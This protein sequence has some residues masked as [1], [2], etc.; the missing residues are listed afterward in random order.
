MLSKDRERAKFGFIG[1]GRLCHSQR[2][3]TPLRQSL[4]Q[5]GTLSKQNPTASGFL[6]FPVFWAMASY[7]PISGLIELYCMVRLF[8]AWTNITE[9]PLYC[10]RLLQRLI[11]ITDQIFGIFDPNGNPH[12]IWPRTGS[13]L[14][15]SAQLAV[16]G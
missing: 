3:L 7:Q 15:L 9:W 12:N 11:Q 16:R 4:Q 13:F 2:G 5:D 6:P 8:C 10:G 1:S 14:L